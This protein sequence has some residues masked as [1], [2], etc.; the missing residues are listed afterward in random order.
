MP[1]LDGPTRKADN[2][3]HTRHTRSM[4]TRKKQQKLEHKGHRGQVVETEWK[5][6]IIRF[7][8]SQGNWNSEKEKLVL[9]FAIQ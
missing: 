2:A 7:S 6:N 1:S 4:H 5:D 8:L 3:R 9:S